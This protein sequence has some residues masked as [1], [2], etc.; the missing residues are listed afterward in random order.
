MQVTGNTDLAIAGEL[1]VT[2]KEGDTF[3]LQLLFKDDNGNL[4]DL[5]NY[6]FAMEVKKR[7]RWSSTILANSVFTFTAN[8][9]GELDIEADASDMEV[10]AGCYKYDLELTNNSTGVVET[11]LQ[12]D[13]II[14][15]DVTN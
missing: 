4:I 7:A 12:G 8:A 11:W 2:C 14:T 13:F 6:S 9:N 3:I 1:D 10:K 5:T 15:S